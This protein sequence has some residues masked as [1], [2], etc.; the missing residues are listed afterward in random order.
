M[1]TI[2]IGMQLRQRSLP[3]K[4]AKAEP[5]AKKPVI[6]KKRKLEG[7]PN[8]FGHPSEQFKSEVQSG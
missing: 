4:E 6:R 2:A 8:L 3:V 5:T 7:T 1:A